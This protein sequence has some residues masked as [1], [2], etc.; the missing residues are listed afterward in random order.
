MGSLRGLFDRLGVGS[1]VLALALPAAAAPE[2]NKPKAG[3][4]KQ[5]D[6][7]RHAKAGAAALGRGEAQTAVRELTLASELAPDVDILLN[8]ARAHRLNG[9]N[10]KAR[11]TLEGL[12]ADSRLTSAKR[13]QVEAELAEVKAKLT[14]LKLE[15]S[16]AGASVRVD[17]R[18][19]GTT[20]L[21]P[22]EL[23]S[24]SHE[25]SVSKP[26]FVTA[27]RKLTLGAGETRI[28]LELAREVVTGRLIVNAT[29]DQTLHLFIDDKDAGLLP[30]QG[31]LP[32]GTYK[33]RGAG[34]KAQTATQEVRVEPGQSIVVSLLSS[35]A[36]GQVRVSTGDPEASIYLN[37]SFLAK[38]NYE[39]ELPSGR[40]QLRVERP[41]YQPY[42]QA[43]DVAPTERV[44]IDQ[45]A[46]TPL[47]DARAERDQPKYEGVFVNVALLGLFGAGSTSELARD[48]PAN[49]A[50]GACDS[51]N[52]AG[53]GLG[54]RVGYSFG[55]LALEGVL[56]GGADA[57]STQ[58]TYEF[59]T[60]SGL[61][62]YY[63]VARD[64]DYAFVRYGFGAGAGARVTSEH[65]V[66]R[67][68]GGLS[69]LLLWRTAQY[70]RATTTR[71]GIPD[72]QDQTSDTT[73]YVAPGLLADIGGLLG[74]TPGV[75]FHFGLALLVEFAP[76]EVTVPGEYTTLGGTPMSRQAY[77]TPEVDVTRGAQVMLGPFLA[78]QFGH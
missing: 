30:F 44:V 52:P 47:G 5:R 3:S 73:N 72:A 74:S 19:V 7:Q 58:A 32:P 25:L 20:P 35:A 29:G 37:D 63:G 10:Q 55:W 34:P 2:S 31:D 65:S 12:L 39:G 70:V 38:G 57:A 64:E 68:S 66:F 33:L 49:S 11:V 41:G 78:A 42:L 4:T 22:L 76:S 24:G 51:I 43:L 21:A 13:S 8:L 40:H 60:T 26:G 61:G 75:K 17:D 69:G 67:F 16:E 15:V 56:L 9:D 1:L 59:G 23:P 45:I 50:G 62:D 77:G 48:C 36:P 53:G 28:A 54:V 46:Y 71:Q 27:T 18:D 14:T 6:A